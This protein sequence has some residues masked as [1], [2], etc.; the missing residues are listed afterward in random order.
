MPFLWSL[1]RTGGAIAIA[2]VFG[3]MAFLV[4][5]RTREFGICL[6]LGA[7]QRRLQTQVL[8]TSLKLV[9]IGV[10]MGIAA[11]IL[12]ERAVGASLPGMAGADPLTYTAIGAAV[13]LV[14][15]AATWGPAR[16]AARIDPTITLRA[17]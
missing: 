4:A 3:V 9:T 8:G 5:S 2:G 16:Q 12:G 17:E 6:A 15:L 14:T 7:D 11:A 13:T 10:A 1:R